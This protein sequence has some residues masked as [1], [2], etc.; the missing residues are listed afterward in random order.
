M[1]ALNFTKNYFFTGLFL[2]IF[3]SGL[4]ASPVFADSGRETEDGSKYG[5]GY[6]SK[7]RGKSHGGSDE[8]SRRNKNFAKIRQE[9]AAEADAARAEGIEP[10]ENQ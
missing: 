7:K 10:D 8:N 5:H 1:K 4:T 6:Y 2:L 3:L 9:Q